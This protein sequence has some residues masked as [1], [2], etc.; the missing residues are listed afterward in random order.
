MSQLRSLHLL[1][2]ED[3]AYGQADLRY[4]LERAEFHNAGTHAL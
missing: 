1:R 3:D 4:R 2:V